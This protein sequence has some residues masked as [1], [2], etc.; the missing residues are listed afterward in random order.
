MF[1]E[2]VNNFCNRGYHIFDKVFSRKYCN[3]L[4]KYLS[5]K[6]KPK[7][8]IPFSKSPWGYGNLL[9]VGPFLEITK[10]KTIVGFCNALLGSKM[11][12]N[13]L[14]INNK[15]AWIGPDVEW[16]QEAFNIK[17]YAPGYTAKSCLKNFTQ[18]FIP[19]DDQNSKNGGLK[20]I[21]YSHKEDLLPYEDFINSNLGHKRRVKVEILNKLFEKYGVLN[22]DFKAG[23][24]LAFNHLL[25]HGSSN[26]L[27]NKDRK[28]IVL[29]CQSGSI[30]KNKEIFEKETNFR[31]KFV[32]NNLKDKID[33]VQ[34]KNIYTDFNKK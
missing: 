15:A 24:V 4:I 34:S 9:N 20:I 8:F 23:D 33:Q 17:T 22:L 27:T 10:N 26:N 12:F 30:S 7:V 14:E 21:P 16:H 32:T 3:E 19:L 13:H 28:S 5:Q 31:R 6:V 11:R 29:Q 18:I 25:V 2:S 1:K